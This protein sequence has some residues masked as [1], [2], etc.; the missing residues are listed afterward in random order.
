MKLIWSNY[1]YDMDECGLTRE[2]MADKVG[3]E[4]R[5]VVED[6]EYYLR[7]LDT[8]KVLSIIEETKEVY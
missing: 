5:K 6:I 4:V 8:K 1:F 2:Q 7:R 3:A